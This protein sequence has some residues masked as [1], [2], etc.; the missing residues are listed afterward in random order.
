M[1]KKPVLTLLLA[2]LA[3]WP[4]LFSCT[5]MEWEAP[6]AG[7]TF[8]YRFAIAENVP[9]AQPQSTPQPQST[10]QSQDGADLPQ[11][12]T[13]PTTR[14]VLEDEGVFWE[15]G[16]KVGIFAGSAACTAANVDVTTR[17]KAIVFSSQAPLPGGTSIYACYPYTEA[18]T[19]VTAAKISIPAVQQ[20]GSLSAMPMAGVPFQVQASDSGTQGVVHFLNLGAVIDFRIYSAQYAGE[21]IRSVTFRADSGAHPVSGEATLDLAGVSVEDERSL[22]LNWPGTV[23]ATSSVTLNQGGIVAASLEQA[24]ASHRYMVLA[25]GRYSGS[26]TV[27]TNAATYTFPFS[28]KEFSRNSLKRI[29]LNLESSTATR[30]AYYYRI[31][32]ADEVHDGDSFLIACENSF[33]N[34]HLLHPVLNGNSFRGDAVSAAITD[35]G[36]RSTTSTDA[37]QV[38]LEAVPG[39]ASEFYIKVPGANDSY[40]YPN[41]NSLSAGKNASTF[42]FDGNGGVT[43]KRENT[44]Y[45]WSTTYYLNCNH[46]TFSSS[47]SS[48]TLAL[49]RKDDGSPRS[50]QPRFSASSFTFVID[51][52]P[53]PIG[54][55]SGTPTLSGAMTTVRYTSGDTSVATVDESSGALTIRGAGQ[56]QITASAEADE[57][58]GVGTA[59]YKL[60]VWEE[61]TFSVENDAV[62]AYLDYVESHPYD[63]DDYSY[64]YVKQFSSATSSTNRLDIPKPVPVSWD[65]PVS[66]T[67]TVVV[68]KDAARS[69]EERMANVTVTSSTSADIYSL[70]PGRKYWY[71]VRNGATQVAEGHFS[72]TGRRRMIKVGDCPFGNVYAN[73]CRDFGGLLTTDGRVV[74]Y[75]KLYRGTCMDKVTAAQRSYILEAM[76]IGLDVDLRENPGSPS[77]D[78]SY[79][80]NGLGLDEI[81]TG[82]ASV[83]RGHTQERYNSI[84]KLTDPARM[85]PTLTRVMNA[86]ENGVGVYIHCKVGADRTAFVCMMLEAILGVRQELCDIDY[87]LTSFCAAVDD[88]LRERGNK[89]QTYYYYPRGIEILNGEPGAT[90]Q[91]KAIHYAVNTL[92]VPMERITAFQ[93]CML[94]TPV[95][96]TN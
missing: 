39:S 88:I 47:S 71:V 94:E 4:A 35:R 77:S 34:A 46:S 40:L 92:N 19:D 67:A 62:A 84:E 23:P 17:P 70:I 7:D 72:T 1:K 55:V 53:L 54:P 66:G 61:P 95:S 3:A 50:Q 82:D 73:N 14:A 87:E 89:R 49:Y 2:A 38:V 60:T 16:D 32:S 83:Y 68:Y 8:E 37:C 15:R 52:Q 5:Q 29:N 11:D 79:M 6:P 13:E 22:S 18:G 31:Q 85:G 96:Q 75:D 10:T 41:N 28:D 76:G 59:S 44:S 93:A 43:I 51:G 90:F 24:S 27:T 63:P 91:E 20:G 78:G 65:S 56:T 33:P 86:A 25:P 48:S 80:Y 36:I 12:Q 45:F 64:S 74:R 9:D 58:Y 42:T 30:E 57:I 69:Q 21:T 81:P 26:I